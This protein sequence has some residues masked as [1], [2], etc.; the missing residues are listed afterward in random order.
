[1]TEAEWLACTD[2]GKAL[3]FIRDGGSKRKTRL[4]GLACCL[5]ILNY[6]QDPRCKDAVKFAE[7]FVEIG[8]APRRGRPAVEKA[9][10]QACLEADRAAYDSRGRSDYAAR[11]I[12]V[13]PSMLPSPPSKGLR[14]S[15]H[16]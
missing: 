14:G 7:R 12:E 3:L 15:R 13:T 11:L 1:M 9:A 10:R 6:I 8:V 4:F 16:N 5:R 2:P